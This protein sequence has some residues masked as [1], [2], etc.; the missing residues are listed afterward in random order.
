MVRGL[1]SATP[2]WPP[3]LVHEAGFC[4]CLGLCASPPLAL[5]LASR[6]PDISS[7][8]P[9]KEMSVQE[10][11]EHDTATRVSDFAVWDDLIVSFASWKVS[12]E[13]DEKN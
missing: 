12:P 8:Q 10:S 9:F 11:G 13:E 5:P 4:G 3:R 7:E 2:S 6:Q 1:S